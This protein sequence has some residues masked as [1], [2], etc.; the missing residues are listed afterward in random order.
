MKSGASDPTGTFELTP[1]AG[2]YDRPL[3]ETVVTEIVVER[4]PAVA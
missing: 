3:T 4:H 1:T 2:S